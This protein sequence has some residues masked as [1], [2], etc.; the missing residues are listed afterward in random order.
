M[1]PGPPGSW[2]GVMST[3]LGT[4]P[5]FPAGASKSQM[6]REGFISGAWT[7]G[8]LATQQR[9]ATQV[10]AVQPTIPRH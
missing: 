1:P 10:A 3:A 4:E 6:V 2:H 7:M 5:T 8:S 9:Q